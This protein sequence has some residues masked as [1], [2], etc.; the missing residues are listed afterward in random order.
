MYWRGRIRS[1]I[2]CQPQHRTAKAMHQTGPYLQN[3]TT[4]EAVTVADC[5]C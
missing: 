5:D 2:V 4:E 3:V 1:R